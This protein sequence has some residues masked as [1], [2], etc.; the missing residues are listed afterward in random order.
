MLLIIYFV[1]YKMK[2]LLESWFSFYNVFKQH[3]RWK[4]CR[5]KIMC[6]EICV[7]GM[8]FHCKRYIQC[9]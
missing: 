2:T 5:Y 9:Y 8:N 7:Q 6:E 3:K 1:E 4:L